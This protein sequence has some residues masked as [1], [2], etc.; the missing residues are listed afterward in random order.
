MA[1]KIVSFRPSLVSS[2]GGMYT[3]VKD[4]YV[5]FVAFGA[6]GAKDWTDTKL[7][8][9]E[10]HGE[11]HVWDRKTGV[12]LDLTDC[13]SY[14]FDDI[15]DET[16]D[17]DVEDTV[18]NLFVNELER[19]GYLGHV[20]E[21]RNVKK[22]AVPFNTGDKELDKELLEVECL[23][24]EQ[25]AGWIIGEFMSPEEALPFVIEAQKKA[26]ERAKKVLREHGYSSDVLPVGGIN[27]LHCVYRVASFGM[28]YEKVN[29]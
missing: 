6:H 4:I 26:E 14:T 24:S 15:E 1:S 10:I 21:F 25:V 20:Y 7:S 9:S 13:D 11:L 28:D 23:P 17:E 16:W 3:N 2:L 27:L 18:T 12:E 22:N 19:L 29:L 8:A 5:K